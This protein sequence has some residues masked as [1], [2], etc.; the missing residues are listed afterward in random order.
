M[1]KRIRLIGMVVSSLLLAAGA[2][3]LGLRLYW[4]AYQART[5]YQAL[6]EEDFP[7]A[8]ARLDDYLKV[9][10]NDGQAHFAAAQACRRGDDL[11][12][13]H[14]HLQEAARCGWPK[15]ELEMEKDLENAQ[16]GVF[17]PVETKLLARLKA[18]SAAEPLI[19]EALTRG[20]LRTHRIQKAIGSTRAWQ[21]RYPQSWRP[22]YYRGLALETRRLFG[23]ALVEYEAASAAAP[24][25]REP[26]RA[27]A[28]VR[29]ARGQLVEALAEYQRDLA[30][31]PN[32]PIALYGLAHCQ[33]AT[34]QAEDAILTL[35]RLLKIPERPA[36]AL[37][38]R[39]KLAL[40]LQG[41]D[42]AL[43]WLRQAEVE[44]P[45]DPGLDEALASCLR[46]LG[47]R[48]AALTYSKHAEYVRERLLRL[49]ELM[50]KSMRRPEES[51]LRS[52]IED[53]YRELQRRKNGSQQG[54]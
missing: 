29:L 18:H 52:E 12:G 19:W 42:E 38:L 33:R 47:R 27:L 48:D 49:E 54:R 5:G 1:R 41:P 14:V 31:F 8:Q 37:L 46:L 40:D 24:G 45:A 6:K 2:G 15:E 50:D 10:P 44:M 9:W 11:P 7:Q 36:V 20:Y 51:R 32:D 22:P 39:G 13:W 43:V 53:I 28:G 35:D 25:R 30:Q 4:A 17:G 21:A 3:D 23:E 26:R 16:S 34:G